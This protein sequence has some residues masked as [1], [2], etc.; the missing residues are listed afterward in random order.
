MLAVVLSYLEHNY[1][2]FLVQNTTLPLKQERSLI[3]T[4]F[5]STILYK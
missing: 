3:S 5:F 4:M 1:Y 2:H